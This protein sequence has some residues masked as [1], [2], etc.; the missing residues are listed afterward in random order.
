VFG[1]FSPAKNFHFEAKNTKDAQEWVDLIRRD[2]R[3]EEEEEEMFLASPIIRR[4]SYGMGGFFGPEA[5]N[6]AVETE[7]LASSSPEPVDPPI[8]QPSI[9]AGHAPQII[10][11]SGLSGNELASHSD[12]SDTDVQRIQGASIE[13]LA[14]QSP[15]ASEGQR[16]NLN[17]RNLSQVSGLNL[18]Q[19]PDRV[20]WQGWIWV[21]RKKAGVRQWKDSWGVLRPRNLILYKD[22]SE[23]AAHLIIPMGSIVN[24]VD[25]D[26]ISRTK[27]HC[28]QIITEEKSYRFATRNEESL[29]QCLGAFKSLL[30]K[31]RELEQKLAAGG[32]AG[33]S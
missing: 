16:P 11:Y 7:R 25:L 10:E 24:V 15:G 31:R 30:S 17:P 32:T 18:E 27:K 4:Q 1:L 5:S 33:T 28:M 8:R 13:N 2:A 21:L 29:L 6:A 19:D 26:P 9:S 12:F 22:D 14:V 23:Y 3:I 20:I